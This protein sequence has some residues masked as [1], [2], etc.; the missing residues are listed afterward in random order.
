MH[1][2]CVL[3]LCWGETPAWPH[4]PPPPSFPWEG[5][6][7]C[8][9]QL[10]WVPTALPS[11]CAPKGPGSC[12]APAARLTCS[13]LGGVQLQSIIFSVNGRTVGVLDQKE[14]NGENQLI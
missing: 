13:L 4:P 11:P 1:L 5:S 3:S 7:V 9:A 10:W 12:P 2:P 14:T 8:E 6:G